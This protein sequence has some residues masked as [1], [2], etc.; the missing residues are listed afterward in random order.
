MLSKD[1]TCLAAAKGPDQ[2][3]AERLHRRYGEPRR[4]VREGR[5]CGLRPEITVPGGPD[6]LHE[7][8]GCAV[9]SRGDTPVRQVPNSD[10]SGLQPVPD[11]WRDILSIDRRGV[12]H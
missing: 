5:R 9:G 12:G 3:R 6:Q 1:K 11:A 7:I 2:G 8:P 4:H 10:P